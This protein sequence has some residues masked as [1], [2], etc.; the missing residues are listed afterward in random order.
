LPQVGIISNASGNDG[1][2]DH[3]YNESVWELANAP[4][5]NG[6][7]NLPL[8]RLCVGDQV[9]AYVSSNL[10]SDG[11][12]YY[13][14]KDETTGSYNSH[15]QS[16]SGT[17][18][19]DSATGECVLERITNGLTDELYDLAEFNPSTK[20]EEISACEIIDSSGYQQSV[21]NWSHI[22]YQ[23]V[24]S[25]NAV[26]AYPGPLDSSGQDFPVHWVRSS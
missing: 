11:Y 9:Y 18:F 3:Q 12:N 15:T 21:G 4:N 24:N 19:S 10:E 1:C 20:T 25:S 8:S 23:I 22:A 26:L 13:Y 14:I 6:A 2:N 17:Y 16:G 7:V 5:D